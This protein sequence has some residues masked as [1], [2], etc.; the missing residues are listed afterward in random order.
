M[1]PMAHVTPYHAGALP[2]VNSA[3]HSSSFDS[4][5]TKVVWGGQ[6]VRRGL[7]LFSGQ[8]ILVAT[9]FVCCCYE[10]GFSSV[11]SFYFLAILLS[12]NHRLFMQAA[13]RQCRS[14]K[15]LGKTTSIFLL[16]TGGVLFSKISSRQWGKRP[17]TSSCPMRCIC[18]TLQQPSTSSL[19][20]RGNSNMPRCP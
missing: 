9:R 19:L 4:P 20:F 11:Y 18:S 5:E 14:V 13:S 17:S 7:V 2:F 16:S 6:S 10:C 3:P 1:L 12:L 8:F 15:P